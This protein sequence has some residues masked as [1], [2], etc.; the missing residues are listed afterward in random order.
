MFVLAA[1]VPALAFSLVACEPDNGGGTG[2][3]GKEDG[4]EDVTS[5]IAVTGLVDKFGCTYADISGYAN[6]NLLPVGSGNPVIGVEV[7]EAK[8]ETNE[9]A[10][11]ATAG[12]LIGNIF[13]VSFSNLSPA[14]EYKYRSFVTYGGVTYYANKYNTFTTKGV[15]NVTSTG[16]ASDIKRT[17]A[18]L[19]ASVQTEGVDA[20]D[21]VSVGLA[22]SADKDAIRA[23]GNFESRK[24]SVQHVEDGVFT[25]SLN[26][27]SEGTTYNFASFTLVGGVYVFSSVKEFTTDVL[28]LETGAVDLGLSVKWAGCNVGAD[29]PEEYGDYFA[30]GET[31][32]R[33]SYSYDNSVTYGF[34]ISALESRGIIGADGNLTSEYDAATANWGSDWRMPTEAE[35]DE[36]RTKCEWEWTSVNGVNGRL[37]TG[38]NGNSIFLPAAGFRFST[39]LSDA[40]SNGYYWSATPSSD[41]YFA[42]ALGFGSDGYGWTYGSRDFGQAVRPVSE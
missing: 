3:G 13:T 26:D 36:L 34:S 23:D 27:L 2:T 19:S 32:T 29:S 15:V 35:Q 39:S 33:S 18:V 21:N 7:V 4:T 9:N 12:S 24:T 17:F 40:G 16:E 42:Y 31:T 1:F 37:V 28:R 38:P 11:Q 8:A 22:W 20:R 14:T 25:V 10:V 6:L 5:E 41:R 30:W